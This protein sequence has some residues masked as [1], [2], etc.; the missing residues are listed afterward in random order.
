MWTV[1]PSSMGVVIVIESR[2]LS[3]A[4]RRCAGAPPVRRPAG[5]VPLVRRGCAPVFTCVIAS[6]RH[7]SL[8]ACVWG[9]LLPLASL[10]RAFARYSVVPRCVIFVSI[11]MSAFSSAVLADTDD[12][13]DL[14]PPTTPS[15]SAASS[16][17]GESSSFVFLDDRRAGGGEPSVL[18]F[19][20]AALLMRRQ[21]GFA[22]VVSELR[23]FASRLACLQVLAILQSTRRRSLNFRLMLT[24][25]RDQRFRRCVRQSWVAIGRL[26]QYSIVG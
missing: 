12:W 7:A 20:K 11:T 24:T 3:S 13:G 17:S 2:V 4:A 15:P 16:G 19:S 26:I 14:M 18:S 5:R 10:F 25:S 9:V 8:W 1:T 6:W 23:S 21:G 22:W